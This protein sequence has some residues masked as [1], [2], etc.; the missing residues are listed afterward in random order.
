MFQLYDQDG[1]YYP[2][3]NTDARGLYA[4]GKEAALLRSKV[5]VARYL[6]RDGMTEEDLAA[7]EAEAS[8]ARAPPSSRRLRR[9]STRRGSPAR[10][11]RRRRRRR[12][13]DLDSDEELSDLLAS[14]DDE[15]Y[16]S[17]SEPRT[18][19]RRSC[20][21]GGDRGSRRGAGGARHGGRARR[22][23]AEAKRKAKVAKG[24][25]VWL[26]CVKWEGCSYRRRSWETAADVK[27]G[28]RRRSAPSSSRSSGGTTRTPTP[29]PRRSRATTC[30]WTASSTSGRLCPRRS[31]RRAANTPGSARK[32]NRG[33]EKT[34]ASPAS[35]SDDDA[36]GRR[37]RVSA[38]PRQVA[39][40][41]VR[42]GH[43]GSRR[44]PRVRDGRE[45]RRAVRAA[46]RP[47]REEENVR[48]RD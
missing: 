32:A 3:A 35:D 42:R 11:A 12:L 30:S 24:K 8:R 41:G 6:E 9:C 14:D 22:V 36:P 29:P 37:R 4:P 28:Q 25:P 40:L 44:V 16:E 45:P 43:L 47:E 1:E 13:R 23:A 18:R 33:K 10:A 21:R 39:R 31:R 19:L 17:E 5:A 15:G 2:F 27:G 26:Y 34:P 7:V 48:G 20:L 38:V 46:G